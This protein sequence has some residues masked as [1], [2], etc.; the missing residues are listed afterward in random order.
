MSQ[1]KFKAYLKANLEA[2]YVDEEGVIRSEDHYDPEFKGE[3]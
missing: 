1:F 3:V 2:I